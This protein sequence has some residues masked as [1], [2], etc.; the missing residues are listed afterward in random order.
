MSMEVNLEEMAVNL[1][2]L[3]SENVRLQSHVN[4]KDELI[5]EQQSII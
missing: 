4:N 1:E 3:N 5:K 2:Q